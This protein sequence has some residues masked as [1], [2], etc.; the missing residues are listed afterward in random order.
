MMPVRRAVGAAI[1]FIGII[2]LLYGIAYGAVNLKIGS[3]AVLT[4][5]EEEGKL[6]VAQGKPGIIDRT[7][8]AV[9]L[10]WFLILIGPAIWQGEVPAAL[11][12]RGG[13]G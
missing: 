13:E 4:F 2:L 3:Y 10:G 5:N 8:A 6:E 9:I 12:P 1:T 11:K 7:A